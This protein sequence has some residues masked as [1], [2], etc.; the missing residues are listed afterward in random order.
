MVPPQRG[1]HGVDA[2]LEVSVEPEPSRLDQVADR[3]RHRRDLGIRRV[4]AVVD[5]EPSEALPRRVTVACRH[6]RQQ[7]RVECRAEARRVREDIGPLPDRVEGAEAAHRRAHRVRVP[8]LRPRAVL[9]VD[10]RLE[11]VTHPVDVTPAQWCVAVLEPPP[12]EEWLAG[13]VDV[14]EQIRAV[15]VTVGDED[16]DRSLYARS[17]VHSVGGE[18]LRE[19]LPEAPAAGRREHIFVLL[20]HVL[21]V[22]A[23]E[24]RVAC[25]PTALVP[26]WKPHADLSLRQQDV[27]DLATDAEEFLAGWQA[28]ERARVEG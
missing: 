13:E 17:L 4:A 15:L 7:R 22:V 25:G 1:A 27:I 28:R 20:H 16:D 6:L 8:R 11:H 19:C 10:R 18:H 12:P 5:V 3:L 23:V 26:R 24:H 9:G 21:A 14:A 2:G